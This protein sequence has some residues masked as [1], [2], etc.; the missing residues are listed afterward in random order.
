MYRRE[1]K[2]VVNTNQVNVLSSCYEL[3]E[4]GRCTVA[5]CYCLHHEDKYR[6]ELDGFGYLR[7]DDLSGL[8]QGTEMENW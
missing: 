2:N 8:I 5:N 6:I 7:L 3:G 4:L 1:N